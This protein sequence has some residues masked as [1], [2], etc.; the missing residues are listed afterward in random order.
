M[1]SGNLGNVDFVQKSFIK[2]PSRG[3]NYPIQ[4]RITLRYV[5]PRFCF[6]VIKYSLYLKLCAAIEPLYCPIRSSVEDIYNVK[7]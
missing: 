3:I 6:G 7:I 1:F 2:L 5:V 4:T